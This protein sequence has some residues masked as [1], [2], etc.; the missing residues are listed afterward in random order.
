M[1]DKTQPPEPIEW[2]EDLSDAPADDPTATAR[3]AGASLESE[4]MAMSCE[5]AKT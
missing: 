3:Y 2:N 1:I 4:L 5:V